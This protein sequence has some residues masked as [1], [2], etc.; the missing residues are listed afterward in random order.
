[1]RSP[2]ATCVSLLAFR[3]D[4]IR[5]GASDGAGGFVAAGFDPFPTV[6]GVLTGLFSFGFVVWLDLSCARHAR[7]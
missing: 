3:I 5:S 2:N 6:I 7:Q 4:L 1:M